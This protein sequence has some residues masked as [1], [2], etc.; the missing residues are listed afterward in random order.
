MDETALRPQGDSRTG[1][2]RGSPPGPRPGALPGLL[3]AGWALVF[4]LPSLYWALGGRAGISSTVS[5]DLVRLVDDGVTWFIAVLWATLLL[6]LV[7]A[8]LGAALTRDRGRRTGWLLLCAAWGAAVLLAFHGLLFVAQGLLVEAGT[9]HV[10]PGLRAISRWYTFLWGPW[11]VAGGVAFGSA[12]RAYL[13][14]VP[15]RRPAVRAGWL[16]AAGALLISAALAVASI[17]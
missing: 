9:L 5:P 10:A 2:G 3:A 16:G 14:R 6:K 13:R 15:D 1:T 17:G 4:A 7:G 8:G 12:A 11:F